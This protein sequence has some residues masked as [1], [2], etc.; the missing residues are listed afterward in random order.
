MLNDSVFES[1]K[2][3]KEKSKRGSGSGDSKTK[4]S[5]KTFKNSDKCVKVTPRHIQ[6]RDG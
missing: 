6:D 3:K 2:P 1:Q 5:G 4:S